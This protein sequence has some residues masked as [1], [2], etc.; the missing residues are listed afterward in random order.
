MVTPDR[1]RTQDDHDGAESGIF[2]EYKQKIIDLRLKTDPVRVRETEFLSFERI[3][4]CQ[5]VF[6]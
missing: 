5:K 1:I 2:S 3:K 6:D 4:L